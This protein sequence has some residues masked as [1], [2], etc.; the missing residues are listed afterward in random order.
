MRMVAISLL[1]LACLVLPTV[2]AAA[3]EDGGQATVQAPADGAGV[4]QKLIEW[5][6]GVLGIQ[7]ESGDLVSGPAT[8]PLG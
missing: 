5:L 3:A 1:V 4:V 2:P 6:E 7:P 8:D